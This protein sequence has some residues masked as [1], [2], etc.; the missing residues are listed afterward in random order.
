METGLKKNL[1]WQVLLIGGFV[2]HLLGYFLN[3]YSVV[4]SGLGVIGDIMFLLG[5]VNFITYLI[6]RKKA[7]KKI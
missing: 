3:T 5:I 2:L 1:S 7:Q 6:R 4:F